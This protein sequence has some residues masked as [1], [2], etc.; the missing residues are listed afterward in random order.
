MGRQAGHHYIPASYLSGFT[1][2]GKKT[3]RFRVQPKNG[4]SSYVTNPIGIC[5]SRDYYTVEGVGDG[6]VVEKFYANEIEPEIKKALHYIQTSQ[7]LPSMENRDGLFMLLATLY[8]RH[9]KARRWLSSGFDD[10]VS[11]VNESITDGVKITNLDA[12]SFGKNDVI[13]SE[14]RLLQS[15]L[16][17]FSKKYYRLYISKSNDHFITSDCPVYL[18]HPDMATLPYFG[19]DTGD[20]ELCVPINKN[21][22]LVGKNEP[23]DEGVF[24]ADERFVALL[25]TK[26]ANS[27]DKIFISSNR[28]VKFVDQTFSVYK[29]SLVAEP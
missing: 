27:S 24:D 12:F 17:H 23:M 16:P 7:Q 13:V 4:S 2:E 14:L 22:A 10:I 9:P 1:N 11:F 18:S 21:A 8:I 28:E 6:L 15:L 3:S 19:I 20:I 5:K 26:I 25:N 29:H